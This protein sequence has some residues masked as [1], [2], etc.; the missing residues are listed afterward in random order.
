MKPEVRTAGRRAPLRVWL[1]W[2]EA[3]GDRR[4]QPRAEWRRSEPAASGAEADARRGGGRDICRGVRPSA[5]RGEEGEV[6]PAG[7]SL[8]AA[9]GDSGLLGGRSRRPT[10]KHE[11][12][13]GWAVSRRR[14]A[15]QSGGWQSL[16][17]GIY[18]RSCDDNL[19]VS[20]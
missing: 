3:P 15:A 12:V 14:A 1:G 19:A 11:R 16:G 17:T 20:Q 6:P 5:E 7:S 18:R 9:H 13:G 10:C 2:T 4:Q 8:A